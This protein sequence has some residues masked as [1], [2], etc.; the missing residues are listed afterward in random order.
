MATNKYVALDESFKKKCLGQLPD[1]KEHRVYLKKPLWHSHKSQICHSKSS[2]G[3][4]L[5]AGWPLDRGNKCRSSHWMLNSIL[6]NLVKAE[7]MVWGLVGS[8]KKRNTQTRRRQTNNDT[9][10]LG[11][12][13]RNWHASFPEM[14]KSENIFNGSSAYQSDTLE[15]Y[16]PRHT[17][18]FHSALVFLKRTHL[19]QGISMWSQLKGVQGHIFLQVKIILFMFQSYIP[20]KH[21]GKS[22][23]FYLPDTH[24]KNLWGKCNKCFNTLSVNMRLKWLWK[25]V[26]SALPSIQEVSRR[27]NN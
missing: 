7:E 20:S 16:S 10:C 15:P 17:Q 26:C 25:D 9:M 27:R 4:F 12:T 6:G 18:S 2:Y 3:V 14:H 1:Y 5:V 21:Q 19:Q 13:H 24:F 8:S 23:N 11:C 22:Y